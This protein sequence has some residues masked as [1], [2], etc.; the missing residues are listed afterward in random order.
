MFE[1]TRKEKQMAIK[2]NTKIANMQNFEMANNRFIF[3]WGI[4][5]G[6]S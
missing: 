6:A 3:F 4:V 5:F 2:D 1:P